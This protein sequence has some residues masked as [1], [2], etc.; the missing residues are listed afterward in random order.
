M[1]TKTKFLAGLKDHNIQYTLRGK[2]ILIQFDGRK[3]H[4]ACVIECPTN[5]Y[6]FKVVIQTDAVIPAAFKQ[7]ME[8]FIRAYNSKKRFVEWKLNDS[9][10]LEIRL[11]I[12]YTEVA[13]IFDNLKSIVVRQTKVFEKINTNIQRWLNGQKTFRGVAIYSYLK[14]DSE[15]WDYCDCKEYAQKLGITNAAQSQ[16]PIA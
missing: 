9:N 5:Y 15:F 10:R 11:L 12:G 8:E 4:Y 14:M 13:S 3:K 6:A 7:D 1:E 2:D 16:K